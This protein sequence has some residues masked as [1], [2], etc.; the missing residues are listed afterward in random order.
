[1]IRPIVLAIALVTLVNFCT[2]CKKGDSAKNL[3]NYTF[4]NS[5]DKAIIV[6]IYGSEEDYMTGKNIIASATI[7]PGGKF[8]TPLEAMKTYYNDCHTSDMLYHNWYLKNATDY[9]AEYDAPNIDDQYDCK[10]MYGVNASRKILLTGSSLSSKWI[11]TVDCDFYGKV[12]GPA[13]YIELTFYK[14]FKALYRTK[15]QSGNITEKTVLYHYANSD[16]AGA[17]SVGITLK[18]PSGTGYPI[19]ELSYN[20][21]YTAYFAPHTDTLITIGSMSSTTGGFYKFARVQ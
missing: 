10:T 5:N 12:M 8:V 13:P 2:G 17:P 9:Q 6:D 11:S 3:R 16:F 14:N 18:E 4:Y 15:D 21:P 19:M 20:M 1:M 7:E